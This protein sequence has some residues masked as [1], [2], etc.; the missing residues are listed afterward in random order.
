MMEP[1]VVVGPGRCGSS[2]VA[3]I[4]YHL[5]VFVGSRLIGADASNPWG[6]FEDWEFV[7]LNSAFL[8]REISRCDWTTRAQQLIEYRRALGVPWGWKDP[9]T[10]N[11]L[12]EYLEFFND[13]RFIRCVR[14]PA[15][16]E[17][18]AVRAYSKLQWSAAD[19]R[20]LRSRRERELDRYLPWYKTLI[21]DFDR[22]REHREE[23]VRSIID[24][25]GLVDVDQRRFNSAVSFIRPESSRTAA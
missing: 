20:V 11:L 15:Q 19:A 7:N 16:I 22:I 24:F 18:S 12:R 17:A 1:I 14:D 23:T 4:L 6:H 8:A 21:V 25:C 13:P 9:R 10:C 2:C 5:G 3:G